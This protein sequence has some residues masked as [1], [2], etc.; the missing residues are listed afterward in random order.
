M[1]APASLLS[2][3]WV[4][5]LDY[6]ISVSSK[7]NEISIWAESNLLGSGPIC[8]HISLGV[9]SIT[10]LFLSNQIRP[11]H[12][13]CSGEKGEERGREREKYMW[14]WLTVGCVCVCVCIS[15]KV[16]WLKKKKLQK[17]PRMSRL[18][19]FRHSWRR[20]YGKYLTN[21]RPDWARDWTSRIVPRAVVRH[22]DKQTSSSSQK[23]FSIRRP[24]QKR[25]LS[26]HHLERVHQNSI[27][28]TN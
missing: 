18:F 14:E 13:T 4:H 12:L 27:S 5:N 10:A 26:W 3:F 2:S 19:E 7:L 15:D 24:R 21:S 25:I 9:C 6:F 8:H 23:W 11:R 20:F 1:L 17:N 22:T 28:E 16:V